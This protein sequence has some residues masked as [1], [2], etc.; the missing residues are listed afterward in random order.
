LR[1]GQGKRSVPVAFWAAL[2]MSSQIQSAPNDQTLP[3]KEAGLFR[4]IVKF[5]ELKQYKKAVKTADQVLKKF[6]NHGETLSMKG[7]ALSSMDKKEEAYDLAR[8]GLKADLRSHVCW[9]VYGCGGRSGSVA[10]RTSHG[11]AAADCSTARTR[12]T[13]KQSNAT[14]KL[15]GWTR[16]TCRY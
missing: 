15:C 14:F 1:I 6:S 7:L 11:R 16:R 9:H 13:A 8:K 4:Q 2:A 3:A 5:Y 12:T 10:W